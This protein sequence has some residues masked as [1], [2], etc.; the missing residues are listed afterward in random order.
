[1]KQ[2]DQKFSS[3]CMNGSHLRVLVEHVMGTITNEK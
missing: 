3:T 2:C 1:M